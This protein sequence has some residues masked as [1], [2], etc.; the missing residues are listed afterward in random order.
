MAP[1]EPQQPSPDARS[2]PPPLPSQGQWRGIWIALA[3]A[4]GVCLVAGAI[5]LPRLIADRRPGATVVLHFYLEG[6]DARHDAELW[7]R[8]CTAIEARANRLGGA[9]VSRIEPGRLRVKFPGRKVAEIGP[10]VAALVKTGRLDFRLI[11]RDFANLPE[12]PAA[13]AVPLGYAIL[14]LAVCDA[15]GTPSETYFAVKRIPEQTG[16]DIAEARPTI[17][18]SGDY[19]IL[20]RFTEEGSRRFAEVTGAHVGEQLAIVLDGRLCS[21]PRIVD[22]IAGG[23]AQITGKFSQREAVELANAFTYPLPLQP[24]VS[25]EAEDGPPADSP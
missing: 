23:Y 22:R 15:D 5:V 13:A 1:T 11:H 16:T 25:L 7:R 9:R 17:S 20:V 8:T 12:R 21:A 3:V 14:P 4:L 2:L 19:E 18:I 24:A 6:K 10:D